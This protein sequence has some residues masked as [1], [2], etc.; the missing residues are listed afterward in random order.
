MYKVERF[1]LGDFAVNSYL[2]WEDNHVL[3]VDPGSHS[4]R[5]KASIQDQNGIVDGILLT[6]AHF[7][8]IAGVDALV[9]EYSCHVYMNAL[10]KPLL[11]NPYLNFSAGMKEVVVHSSV[12]SLLPGE[13]KI[14]KFSFTFIDAPGHSEGSSMI[15]WHDTLISGDVLF[16]GSIGR[17]DLVT[18]NN[19]QM[20]Q[21]LKMIKTLDPDLHVYPGHGEQTTLQDEFLSNPYLNW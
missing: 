10:D 11:K 12:I 14:G 13:Q 20:K 3:I 5:M 7:D 19:T 4:K 16:K 18:S 21:T 6:H 1:V 2:L 9:K 15:L 17:T 8:H